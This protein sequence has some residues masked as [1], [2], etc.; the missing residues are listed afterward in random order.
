MP[1]TS[2]LATTATTAIVSATA[3]RARLATGRQLARRSRGEAS[4]AASTST[5][6]TNSASASSGSS[7]S[8]GTPG[9][10]ASAAP[11]SATS[12]GYGAPIRRATAA[13]AAPP[14]SSATTTS[15]TSI[16]PPGARVSLHVAAGLCQGAEDSSERGP[17]KRRHA[18]HR[19]AVRQPKEARR[20]RPPVLAVLRLACADAHPSGAPHA[21]LSV[22]RTCRCRRFSSRALWDLRLAY[23]GS[24]SRFAPF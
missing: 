24:P 1:G 3:P 19:A 8:V 11:A 20:S 14:R 2:S 12:A 6:A 17:A 21:S 13:S 18:R 23:S 9:M 22:S 15:K 7:T 5:G 16:A 10:S 4:N